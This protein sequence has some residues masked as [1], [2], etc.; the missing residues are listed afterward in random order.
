M[1]KTRFA[2][3]KCKT[4]FIIPHPVLSFSGNRYMKILYPP[5]GVPNMDTISVYIIGMEI[6]ERV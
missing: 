2:A 6:T 5:K 4:G 3:K 1:R